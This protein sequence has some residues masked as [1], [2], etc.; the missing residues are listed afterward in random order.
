MLFVPFIVNWVNAGR[1]ARAPS[2]ARRKSNIDL[3]LILLLSYEG[4]VP[5]RIIYSPVN[6]NSYTL[7]R[8]LGV[9]AGRVAVAPRKIRFAP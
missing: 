7:A 8:P 2:V 6:A 3:M 1:R 9:R 5:N 4:F